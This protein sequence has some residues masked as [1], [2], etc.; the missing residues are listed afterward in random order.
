MKINEHNDNV[1]DL[2]EDEISCEEHLSSEKGYKRLI[3]DSS[4]TDIKNISTKQELVIY[5]IRIY[6]SYDKTIL[7]YC[8]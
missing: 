4:K 6:D 8:R 5:Q 3:F 1:D 7:L 2:F